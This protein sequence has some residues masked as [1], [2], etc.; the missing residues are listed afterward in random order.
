MLRGHRG[1]CTAPAG[2]QPE[3]SPLLSLGHHLKLFEPFACARAGACPAQH[4]LPTIFQTT[5]SP[6]PPPTPMTTYPPAYVLSL[7]G[8]PPAAPQLNSDTNTDPS[9]GNRGKPR[10]GGSAGQPQPP[11]GV[12]CERRQGGW[13]VPRGR[14]KGMARS[15]RA[16]LS[17]I[18]AGDRR[19]RIVVV[20][21]G[22]TSEHALEMDIPGPKCRG[23]RWSVHRWRGI[24]NHIVTPAAPRATDDHLPT[25]VRTQPRWHIPPPND[26]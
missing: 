21:R 23:W 6:P 13:G 17:A 24:P 16:G 7:D 3:C 2:L 18:Q 19:A 10:A 25:G 8:V 15:P 11:G 22:P 12:C 14:G 9:C 5:W 26:P 20:V 4:N 1:S